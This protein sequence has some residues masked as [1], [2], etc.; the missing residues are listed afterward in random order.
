M[1]SKSRRFSLEER[2]SL[3]RKH[4]ASGMTVKDYAQAHGIARSTLYCWSSRLGI[5]YSRRIKRSHL[6]ETDKS[7][8]ASDALFKDKQSG[9][10]KDDV[11]LSPPVSDFS[12]IDI[13][14]QISKG[15][16]SVS[17]EAT[18]SLKS[19]GLEIQLPNGVRFKLEKVPFHHVWDQVIELVR[20]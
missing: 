4:E 6:V 20:G 16:L 1:K 3:L 10:K 7:T 15:P 13:T 8:L 11:I 14:A 17:Q 5:P 9:Y 18:Q 19:C 2:K 12:F